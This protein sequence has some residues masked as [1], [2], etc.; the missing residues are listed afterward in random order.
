M[1]QVIDSL[2]KQYENSQE[3]LKV[4]FDRRTLTMRDL[5]QRLKDR[6]VT[7]NKRKGAKL[8]SLGDEDDDLNEGELMALNVGQV[9]KCSNC[10]KLG[11]TA[12]ECWAP[13]GGK[14]GQGPGKSNRRKQFKGNCRFCGKYGHKASECWENPKSPNYRGG[15]KNGRANQ[16]STNQTTGYSG[17][18]SDVSFMAK[19]G[20]SV[21][22]N[23]ENVWVADTGATCHMTGNDKGF[24]EWKDSNEQVI[25]GNGEILKVLKVGTW[26]GTVTNEDGS[27]QKITLKGTKYVPG[28]VNNLFAIN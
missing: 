12:A 14:A 3:M 16:A 6:F 17:Y 15:N 10:G 28:L 8:V 26:K 4:E 21:P 9:P 19:T 2:P 24:V 27:T 13:G 11:H 18:E 22:K 23:R 5:K 7:L 25:F 1:L 20:T